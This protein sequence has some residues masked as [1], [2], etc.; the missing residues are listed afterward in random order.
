MTGISRVQRQSRQAEC[1]HNHDGQSDNRQSA[2]PV[3]IKK[4]LLKSTI[5]A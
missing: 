1:R 3:F 4:R 5:S 2:S